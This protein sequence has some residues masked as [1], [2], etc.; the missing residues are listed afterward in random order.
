MGTI[1][2]YAILSKLYHMLI[3]NLIPDSKIEV[4]DTLGSIQLF[5]V[6]IFQVVDYNFTF[7]LVIWMRLKPT[8]KLYFL[9]T[10]LYQ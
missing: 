5:Q 6:F 4:F 8:F 7:R 10:L 3:S 1:L 2:L 9:T